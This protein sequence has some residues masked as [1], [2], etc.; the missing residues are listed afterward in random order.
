VPYGDFAVDLVTGEGYAFATDTWADAPEEPAGGGHCVDTWTLAP[1]S[2]PVAGLTPYPGDVKGQPDWAAQVVL[3]PV[4]LLTLGDTSAASVADK[5]DAAYSSVN[6]HSKGGLYGGGMVNSDPIL[7][8]ASGDAPKVAT[9]VA[10]LVASAKSLGALTLARSLYECRDGGGARLSNELFNQVRPGAKGRGNGWPLVEGRQ[11]GRRGASPCAHASPVARAPSP[12][13]RRR[14]AVGPGPA[15]A[16]P[17]ALGHRPDGGPEGPVPHHLRRRRRDG[18]GG[19]QQAAGRHRGARPRGGA[20]WG[21]GWGRG[22]L[23]AGSRAGRERGSLWHWN[24]PKTP[25]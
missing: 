2:V 23:G 25:Y 3:T 19:H 11:A 18:A 1:V 13:C 22:G 10:A 4:S 14:P 9:G 24:R 7:L 21:L 5:Y 17:V 8:V 6:V 16:G 12:P 15:E 20:V